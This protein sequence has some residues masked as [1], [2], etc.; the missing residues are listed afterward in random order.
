MNTS[1]FN[2][3]DE[4]IKNNYKELI[5]RLQTLKING[6]VEYIEKGKYLI[7]NYHQNRGINLKDL[8]QSFLTNKLEILESINNNI[9]YEDI[10]NAETSSYVPDSFFLKDNKLFYIKEKKELIVIDLN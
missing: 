9:I 3:N 5:D 4:N 7:Y 8:S 2:S 1:A 6:D 10:L